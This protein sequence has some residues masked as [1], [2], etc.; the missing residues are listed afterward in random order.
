MAEAATAY[1][2]LT[3]T[4]FI[5]QHG[6]TM[7][8]DPA[9]A[10][11][12]M[13]TGRGW[14]HWRCTLA[15]GHREMTVYFSQGPAICREPTVEDV[16]DCLAMDASGLGGSFEDWCNEFGYDTDSRR[17]ERTFQL[18]ERQSKQLQRLIG[19]DAYET[20]LYQIERL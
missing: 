18:I 12:N 10:N 17:A 2:E 6:I 11:P 8:A 13:P 5:Q 1:H 19:A 20:L 7:S 4:A 3:L 9:D 15:C 16:L 14:Q